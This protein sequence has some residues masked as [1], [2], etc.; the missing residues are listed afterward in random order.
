MTI[1]LLH[2]PLLS[3]DGTWG[4]LPSL[5]PDACVVVRV[6]DDLRRPYARRYVH[7]AAGQVAG[8]PL[9]LIAHSGSGPL[10]PGVIAALSHRGIDVEGAVF[11]DAGMPA[12]G[13]SRLESIA[14]DSSE[15]AAE[16]E[17]LLAAGGSYPD[18]TEEQLA[19]LVPDPVAVLAAVRPRRE[20]FWREPLPSVPLPSAVR[21]AYVQL[22]AAYEASAVSA[23]DLGWP[24]A[25]ADLGHLAML[26]APHE[27]A[28]LIHQVL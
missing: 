11:L 28:R 7:Q 1:V 5:L 25:S 18:W 20:D 3:P 13:L 23:R 2:S 9:V 8:G 4:S 12:P 17:A 10:L 16:L 22:S 15:M 26:G 21:A 14:R 19:D 27:V 24:V 6:E